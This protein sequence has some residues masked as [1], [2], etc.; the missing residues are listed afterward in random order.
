MRVLVVEDDLAAR[1][2]LRFVLEQVG[3]HSV[4]EA[5]D[6]QQGFELADSA[7]LIITDLAMPNRDGFA[8]CKA[9]RAR[10]AVPIIAVSA[11]RTLVSDR[12]Q[13]LHSGA[14]D[15]L[16]K[17]FEPAELLARIEALRRRTQM[18]ARIERAGVI[19]VG[20]LAIDLLDQTVSVDDRQPISLTPTE[21]RLLARLAQKPGD[22]VSREA[23][24]AALWGVVTPETDATLATYVMGVRRKIE[25]NPRQP[26]YIQTVRQAGYRLA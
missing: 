3:G 15:Y 16:A 4:I 14:D 12:V 19:R 6:G 20:D 21:C 22:T 13:A 25:P 24:Q 2:L 11:A 23:L 1:K 8:L 18:S 17:P 5:E 9:L 26:R 7:D 10:S